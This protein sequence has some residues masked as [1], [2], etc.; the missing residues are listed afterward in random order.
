MSLF[1]TTLLVT[2]VCCLLMGVGLLLRGRPLTGGCGQKLPRAL[3]CA[4]CPR[5]GGTA[6]C[7]NRGDH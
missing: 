1:V 2:I 5:R 3:R 6:T 4:G 7:P